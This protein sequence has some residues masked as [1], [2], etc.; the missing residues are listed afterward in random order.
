MSIEFPA[1]KTGHPAPLFKQFHAAGNGLHWRVERSKL[2]CSKGI[3][4]FRGG[5]IRS[6]GDFIAVTRNDAL[7]GRPGP[8]P[9]LAQNVYQSG[10][11][12]IRDAHSV[13][14]KDLGGGAKLFVDDWSGCPGH[15]LRKTSRLRNVSF[16]HLRRP[17]PNRPALRLKSAIPQSVAPAHT[18]PHD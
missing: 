2:I 17:T 5:F 18:A 10:N 8:P 6:R 7:E 4:W 1:A 14:Q 12:D 15:A 3:T 11:M 13:A 16:S 9:L